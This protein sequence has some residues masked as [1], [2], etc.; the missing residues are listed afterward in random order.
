M[1]GRD[2]G[3]AERDAQR[4]HLWVV[5]DF[6]RRIKSIVTRPQSSRS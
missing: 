6:H 5:A 3:F 2:A 1:F 4:V